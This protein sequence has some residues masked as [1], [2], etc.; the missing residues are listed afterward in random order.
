MKKIITILLITFIANCTFA[1]NANRKAISEFVEKIEK[2]NYITKN[3]FSELYKQLKELHSTGLIGATLNDKNLIN[4]DFGFGLRAFLAFEI[5][6]D[7]KMDGS[8]VFNE[9]KD[10]T[11]IME[12]LKKLAP[13]SMIEDG[14]TYEYTLALVSNQ[15]AYLYYLLS[16][17]CYKYKLPDEAFYLEKAINNLEPYKNE[18]PENYC[19]YT[20]NLFEVK[21]TFKSNY[22]L[23]GIRNGLKLLNQEYEL[24]NEKSKN[25]EIQKKAIINYLD[26]AVEIYYTSDVLNGIVNLNEKYEEE[27][28]G[29]LY[30][31]NLITDNKIQSGIAF[32][33]IY[34]LAD[35]DVQDNKEEAAVLVK[36]ELSKHLKE[37][38]VD[39]LTQLANSCFAM[40]NKY[41]SIFYAELLN[42]KPSLGLKEIINILSL[43]QEI[44][45]I[46]KD[47]LV[48][49]NNN[50][51][52]LYK[53]LDDLAKK[54]DCKELKYVAEDF[55]V[56]KNT[57]KEVEFNK[58]AENCE[59]AIE[60]AKI[61]KGKEAAKSSKKWS[62][63]N[64][65][66][67]FYIGVFPLEF[68]SSG[69]K[70]PGY[71]GN[72][73][74]KGGKKAF[75]LGYISV[76]QKQNQFNWVAAKSASVTILD[77]YKSLWKGYRAFASVR[78]YTGGYIFSGLK[79]MYSN[80]NLL[81]RTVAVKNLTTNVTS[82]VIFD[83]IIEKQ[84]TALVLMGTN[85]SIVNPL[86]VD[87]AL[88]FGGS[89][90]QFD[91]G[92]V[93]YNNATKFEIPTGL[94]TS[95]ST[96]F[97]P[98]ISLTVSVGLNIKTVSK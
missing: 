2:V 24:K 73:I 5:D 33:K 75:E 86:G 10:Y 28:L 4:F 3:N 46:D 89:Y 83:K 25:F 13:L 42:R 37:L 41:T 9:N 91:G 35:E 95:K 52:N 88:G 98:H 50:S 16:L 69:T 59:K 65:N 71:G 8:T 55:K 44:K 12:D 84:Y 51:Q 29:L 70:K 47:A 66:S 32:L 45:N 67:G 82:N 90:C 15:C 64:S 61:K 14:K 87:V 20:M 57:I 30:T 11:A 38:T 6:N 7:Y 74:F 93:E 81:P 77:D 96:Y 79:V 27:K 53:Q 85:F 23:E 43:N 68:Q 62:K 26:K 22:N 31:I 58:K 54:M 76:A 60:K 80:R 94:L 17:Y 97:S 63:K 18:N 1:Q 39:E 72:I 40:D 19:N 56:I 78:S 34:N 49:I 48:V 21:Y 92:R 36:F